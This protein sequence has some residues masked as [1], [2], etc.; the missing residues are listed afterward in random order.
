VVFWSGNRLDEAVQWRRH[1]AL[2]Y[3]TSDSSTS[4]E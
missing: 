3:T 2:A 1:G 4:D